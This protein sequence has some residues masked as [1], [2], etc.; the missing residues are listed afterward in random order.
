LFYLKRESLS[1]LHWA[2]IQALSGCLSYV[3]DKRLVSA[4]NTRQVDEPHTDDQETDRAKDSLAVFAISKTFGGIQALRSVSLDVSRG[5][6][7]GLIGPNGSGKTTLLNVVSGLLSPSSGN[8]TLTGQDITGMY[9]DKIARMGI[10]RTFQAIRLF[11]RLTVLEN[12]LVAAST[13]RA[14][15]G[16][17]DWQR[18]AS[19]VLQQVGIAHLADQLAGTLPYGAQR[20]VEIARALA[21]EPRYLLIDEPA[22]G[23]NEEE[24]HELMERIKAV[25][26]QAGCGILVVDHDLHF[27]LQLCDRVVVLN[28]GQRISQG[29]PYDV[30]NDPAVI[31][32]YL[33]EK[34]AKGLKDWKP[35]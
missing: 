35:A 7:L 6:I 8:V 11:T 15:R 3:P 22:A 25:R 20:R 34:V 5:E 17:R 27:I 2:A 29:S 30:Y 1:S 23:M 32:A 14:A 18:R 13:G 10:G 33:G 31:N 4:M 16:A 12:V 26:Q 21:L 9:P 19:A 28:E 24:A